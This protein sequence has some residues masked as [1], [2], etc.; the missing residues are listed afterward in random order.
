MKDFFIHV[1]FIS[2][3]CQWL[4]KPNPHFSARQGFMYAMGLLAIVAAASVYNE[5][6][7]NPPNYFQV[8]QLDRSST[9]GDVKTQ[10]RRMSLLY[11]PDK[12]P[13]PTA[14]AEFAKVREAYEVLSNT[15]LREIYDKFGMEGLQRESGSGESEISLLIGIG[16]FYIVWGIMVFLLTIGRGSS[17]SRQAIYT[18]LIL[19]LILEFNWKFSDFDVVS[20]FP[21]I[22]I[23]EKVD[24]LHRIFPTFMNACIIV[25]MNRYEDPEKKMWELMS[26]VLASNMLIVESLQQVLETTKGRS[27]SSSSGPNAAMVSK[28]AAA[29]KALSETQLPAGVKIKQRQKPGQAREGSASAPAAEKKSLLNVNP[30][31]LLI[32]GFMVYNYFFR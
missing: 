32:V 11:H 29:H 2:P 1:F 30:V 14:E 7:N 27:D 16:T 20:L 17:V 9:M 10:F 24:I 3:A 23:Y 26:S 15:K 25:K 21:R 4:L 28:L 5:I 6:K 12:N 19:L 8:L 22:T 18:G 13:S 31:T